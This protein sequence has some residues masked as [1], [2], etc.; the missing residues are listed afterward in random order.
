MNERQLISVLKH[1]LKDVERNTARYPSS[2]FF[3]IRNVT[4]II[5]ESKTDLLFTLITGKILKLEM[6]NFNKDLDIYFY[7]L[8]INNTIIAYAHIVSIET[9]S[10]QETKL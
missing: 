2:E 1:S 6:A 4:D 9:I 10:E 3:S 8:K 7:G 5:E